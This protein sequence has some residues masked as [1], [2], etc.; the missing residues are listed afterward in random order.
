[1]LFGGELRIMKPVMH[2]RPS[3]LALCVGRKNNEKRIMNPIELISDDVKLTIKLNR[4]TPIIG[5][6]LSIIT[7][8][9]ENYGIYGI[10]VF[11][12][13]EPNISME[14]IKIQLLEYKNI[15]IYNG[16]LYLYL[17]EKRSF[18]IK[19][20]GFGRKGYVGIDKNG[21]ICEIRIS[22]DEPKSGNP[23]INPMKALEG[24]KYINSGS[25]IN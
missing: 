21:F 2:S 16:I 24:L 13:E 19:G 5:Y 4:E 14:K 18:I 20:I 3:S 17:R 23:Y 6:E 10:E 1:M 9:N 7:D 8:L 22:W 25:I 15:E 12:Y 11:L